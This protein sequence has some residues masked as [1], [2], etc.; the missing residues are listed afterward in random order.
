M[1]KAP[2]DPRF[3]GFPQPDGDLRRTL[4]F[5]SELTSKARSAGSSSEKQEALIQLLRIALQAT[6]NLNGVVEATAGDPAT[7][8]FIEDI[9]SS[10]H[11]WPV[12]FNE[13]EDLRRYAK[14]RIG[15]LATPSRSPKK[16]TGG[17]V[18]S[19]YALALVL[20]L[21]VLRA[22]QL[23]AQ[24]K[25]SREVRSA[26]QLRVKYHVASW[27]L[28]RPKD[29]KKEPLRAIA[30]YRPMNST[31]LL[32]LPEFTKVS[33]EAW[34]SAS[35]EILGLA[36]PPLNEINELASQ[37][38]DRDATTE[39]EIRARITTRIGRAVVALAP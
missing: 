15:Y 1:T 5:V 27:G 10:Q 17:T 30:V 34:R 18:F 22:E 3:H 20:K 12:P 26:C 9:V 23:M 8:Q 39:A 14:L 25:L 35:L 38:N 7:L 6:R 29:P 33:A 16:R 19:S 11:H 13:T 24:P 37:I 21:R 36:L 2:L 32:S 31:S 4:D 28:D